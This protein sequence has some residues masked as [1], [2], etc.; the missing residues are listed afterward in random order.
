MDVQGDV[1]LVTPHFG[2][3]N[4]IHRDVVLPMSFSIHIDFPES[5]LNMKN[6]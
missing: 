3:E 6:I 2:R 4:A 1:V 5:K